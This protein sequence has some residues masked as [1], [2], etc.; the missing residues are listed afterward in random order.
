M[1][2]LLPDKQYYKQYYKYYYSKANIKQY[3]INTIMVVLQTVL[4]ILL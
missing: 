4:Q 3:S 1:N 2:V